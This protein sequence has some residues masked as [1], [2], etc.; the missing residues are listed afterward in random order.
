MLYRLLADAT[1]LAHL[2]F[3][4]F[5][6]LGGFLLFRWP[7]LAWLHV[8]VFLWG[9]AIELIGWICPLTYLENHFREAG[10]AEGYTTSFVEHYLVPLI[11]P[12]LLFPGGFPRAGFMAIGV[13]VLALNSVI[14]WRIWKRHHPPG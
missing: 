7:K 9:V 13:F 1:V 2:S 10:R 12:E 6:L 4:L 14:Y 8:P 3:I 5:V 11:Y